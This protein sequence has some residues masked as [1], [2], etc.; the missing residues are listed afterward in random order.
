M[1]KGK[2]Y[3]YRVAQDAM[4]WTAEIIR[5][6]TSKKTGVSKSQDGFTTEADAQEWAQKELK[7]FL[8]NLANETSVIQNNGGEGNRNIFL[9]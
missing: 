1:T 9:F 6:I 8:K 4:G 5:K 2:K 3:D 7:D